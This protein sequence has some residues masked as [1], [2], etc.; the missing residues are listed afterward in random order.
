MRFL[1][2]LAAVIVSVSLQAEQKKGVRYDVDTKLKSEFRFDPSF[3]VEEADTP[4]AEVLVLE[5][6]TVSRS[7]TMWN[8]FERAMTQEYQ[9]RLKEETF[10]L[11]YGGPF[12]SKDFGKVRAQIGLWGKAGGYDFLKIRW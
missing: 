3:R 12:A 1:L 11:K 10:T 4:E 5:K 2:L 7:S 9:A 8:H 6:I